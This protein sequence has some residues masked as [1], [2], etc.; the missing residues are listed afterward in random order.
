M[1]KNILLSTFAITCLFSA[2]AVDADTS[3]KVHFNEVE[4]KKQRTLWEELNIKNYTYTYENASNHGKSRWDVQ[5]KDGVV[6]NKNNSEDYTINEI[7]DVVE[8]M[9]KGAL[10]QNSSDKY[11]VSII[12]TYNKE[13]YF[14]EKIEYDT[15]YRE[16]ILGGNSYQISVENFVLN[17]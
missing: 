6:L 16:N 5:V 11:S 15:S 12:V 17:N 7:F 9:Y 1:K 2:C 13:F 4:F 8:M 10:K 3:Y 14:P